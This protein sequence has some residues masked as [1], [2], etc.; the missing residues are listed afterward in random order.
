MGTT[1]HGLVYPDS[2]S[3]PQAWVDFQN[4]AESVETAFDDNEEDTGWTAIGGGV[5]TGTLRYRVYRG[6][7]YVQCDGSATTTSG[8]ALTLN[9]SN[10]LP[11][12]VRPS[13]QVRAGAYCAAY[14]GFMT[15]QTDG[16][17]TALQSSGTSKSTVASMVTYPLG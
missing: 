16:L 11:A 6:L 15:V 13:V 12:D 8:V 2:N 1:G 14:P 5:V 7:V 9:P 17:I 3:P 10:A 4:L